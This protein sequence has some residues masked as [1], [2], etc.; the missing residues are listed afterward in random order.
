VLPLQGFN[1]PAFV[2]GRQAALPAAGGCPN[3]SPA[4]LGTF[5]FFIGILI[6]VILS[7][8]IGKYVSFH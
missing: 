5:T 3:S 4:V 7:N 6:S 1:K 8:D 2:P